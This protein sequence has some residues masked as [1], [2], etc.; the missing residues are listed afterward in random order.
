MTRQFSSFLEAGMYVGTVLA[1]EVMRQHKA[2]DRGAAVIQKEAKA[3]IGNYQDAEPPF[4][5]W[6]ELADS[7]KE[8]RLR[9]GYTE[10]DPLL[11]SGELRD[12]VERKVLDE[13]HAAVGSDSDVAVYQELGTAT[14]PPRSFLGMAA[15]RK[16]EQVA[17]I[18]GEG[19]TQALVGQKV[20]GGSIDL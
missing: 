10:N 19:V 16:G 8:D 11:R 1:A 5:P 15:V 9:Q 6:A 12:S 4:A 18:I 14:I 2:L 3:I 13:S 17:Q 20:F 7:T